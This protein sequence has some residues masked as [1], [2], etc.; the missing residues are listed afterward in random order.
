MVLVIKIP[1]NEPINGFSFYTYGTLK[2]HLNYL[3]FI[4]IKCEIVPTLQVVLIEQALQ[5]G[6]ELCS[7]SHLLPEDVDPECSFENIAGEMKTGEG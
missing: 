1:K 2:S 6:L 7:S 4:I 5:L 3:T